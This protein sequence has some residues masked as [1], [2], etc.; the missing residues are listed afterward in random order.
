MSHDQ[1]LRSLLDR[2]DILDCLIRFSRGIDRLDREI[3]LSAFHEDATI[4]A[5]PFV[6]NPAQLADWSFAMHETMQVLTQHD[7]LNHS[8]DIEGDTAH[9][10]TYY[11]FVARNTDE[12]VMLAGGRYVDRLERRGDDWKIS[13]RTNIIEWSA[14]PPHLPLPFGDVPGVDLN[15]RGERSREDISYRRPLENVRERNI[16]SG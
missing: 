9:G 4:A 12:S 2:Q 11:L 16:P 14:M 1:R 6:G 8:C 15:G 13:L 3:F 10:E 5:G 7:L